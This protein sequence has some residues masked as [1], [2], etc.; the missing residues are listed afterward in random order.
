MIHRMLAASALALSLSLTGTT[1]MAVSYASG[2]RNVGGSMYE[3]VLNDDASNVV[4]QRTGESALNLGALTPGR[5]TFD[6]GAASAFDIEVSSV[7]PSGWSEIGDTSNPFTWFERPNGIA[8]NSDPSSPFF[9]TIYVANATTSNVTVPGARTMG[10][11]IYALTAD[12]KGLNPAT[13]AE[14]IDPNDTSSVAAPGWTVGGST[15][16][17]W[18]ISF[19]EANNLIVQDYS[20]A[21]GGIKYASPD[22]QTGGLLL[23][24]EG[25]PA[26]GDTGVNH[27]STMSDV[28]ATGSVG[29]GLT[30]WAI[31]QDLQSDSGGLGGNGAAA[32]GSHLWR[33]DVGNATEYAGA[34]NLVINATNI[35]T[36]ANGERSF[37]NLN[38][39]DV[40]ADAAYSADNDLWYITQRR[41][42][43]NEAGL[44]VLQ[45]DGVDGNSPTIEFSTLD[46]TVDNGYDGYPFEFD[47]ITSDILRWAS[48]VELS[49]DGSELYVTRSN[50]EAENPEGASDTFNPLLGLESDVNGDVLVI[51]LD[52]NGIPEITID[53]QGDADPNN[54][55]I[56]NWESIDLQGGNAGSRSNVKIDAAGNL[57]ATTNSNEVFQIFSPGGSNKATYSND[58]ALTAGAFTVEEL[59]LID[60]DYN[61]DG[62]VDAADYTI[63]RDTLGDTVSVG[64]GADGN[65]NGVIDAGDYTVWQTNYGATASSLATAVPEPS[66]LLMAIVGFGA[67]ASRRR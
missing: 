65:G 26:L 22:L 6:L 35:P 50:V 14:I 64:S 29:N 34:A 46:W 42:S 52:E 16:S 59:I 30:L 1:A 60:G 56:T 54:D 53:D 20:G 49:A 33:W 8:V 7:N 25:G 5:H 62:L 23:A 4:I 61:G 58:A 12:S 44:L 37:L 3:F 67:L 43:G 32:D 13:F 40:I 39:I 51:P 10:D 9:G 38:N 21:N 57:Y 47:F 24:G 45:A 19:D 48:K 17:P 31:D 36:A 66:A 28:T 18:G 27:G 55:Q 2:V 11:G 15:F 41:A 63:Y